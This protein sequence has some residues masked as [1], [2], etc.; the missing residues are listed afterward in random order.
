MWCRLLLIDLGNYWRN[1][2]HVKC[3]FKLD[4]SRHL[5]LLKRA[6]F[7]PTMLTNAIL[8]L[9][10]Y[11]IICVIMVSWGLVSSLTRAFI[12]INTMLHSAE[13]VHIWQDGS[14]SSGNGRRLVF[15][16]S[17]VQIPVPYSGRTFFTFICCIDTVNQGN[18]CMSIK[19][20]FECLCYRCIM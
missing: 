10:D 2:T 7:E 15:Q 16:R 1:T 5:S 8:A 6:G 4:L 14:W 13:V 11:A 3:C 18:W 9:F 12:E 19:L 17:W 20:R